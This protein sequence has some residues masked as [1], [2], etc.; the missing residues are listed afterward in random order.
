MKA[1]PFYVSNMKQVVALATPGREDIIDAV[2]V[3]GPCTVPDIAKFVGRSRNA[4]YY[5]VRALRDVGLLL[6]SDVQR[7]GVKTTSVYDLPGRP[8][9][10]KYSLDTARSRR[11]VIKLAQSRF[12]SGQRGFIRAVKPD[13]VTEGPH[14]NLWVAHWKGWLTEEDLVEA[15]RLLIE[16]VD[17]FRHGAD[18]KGDRT[19][20][21]LTFAIAPVTPP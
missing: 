4:L 11:A 14:R 16:L 3:L 1:R 20:H 7:E 21:E 12:K 18:A 19:P 15:N 9:I 8:L 2:A 17:V 6:E 10:V 5:H 13:A